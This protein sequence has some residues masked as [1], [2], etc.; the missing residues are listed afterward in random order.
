MMAE[1]TD[2][3]LNVQEGILKVFSEESILKSILE[4]IASIRARHKRPSSEEI[5]YEVKRSNFSLS[6]DIFK[7]C[8][9]SLED[10]NII[11]DK[12]KNDLESFFIDKLSTDSTNINKDVVINN[13][14]SV[15]QTIIE[16]NFNE[17][18]SCEEKDI[19]DNNININVDDKTNS[20]RPDETLS[21]SNDEYI[22]NNNNTDIY[23]RYIN[24][25]EEEVNFLRDEVRSKGKI[26]DL[27]LENS[28]LRDSQNF[29]LQNRHINFT[30]QV[31]NF[32][33]PKRKT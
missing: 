9:R 24:K 28:V 3:N 19:N 11:V 1:V 7:E 21:L 22:S 4:A 10:K 25:L 18:G 13:S 2:V 29:P 20:Q 23:K 5:F 32:E 30:P 12:C 16:N 27:L 31:S 17:D 14:N 15:N 8:M 6:I 26:I 33:F